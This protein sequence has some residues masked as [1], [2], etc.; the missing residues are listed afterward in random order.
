MKETIY[1][2]NEMAWQEAKEYPSGAMVKVLREGGPAEGRTILL[3]LPPEWEMEAHSHTTVEQ[4]YVLEG[5]YRSQ[6]KVFPAGSY[7]FIPRET[8]HGPFTVGPST[9]ILV[10]WD[11]L[12]A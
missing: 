1:N 2:T 3:K 4:H 9:V 11:P 6:G 10:I 8:N 5:E 12:Q 7:Q